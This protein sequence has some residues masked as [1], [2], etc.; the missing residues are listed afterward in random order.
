MVEV[1][2]IAGMQEIWE[3]TQGSAEICV[4]VLDGVVDQSHPCFAGASLTRLSSLVDGVA[5][6]TGMMSGH[7]THVASTI[8]GQQGSPVTGIAPQCRGLIIP[9]F[10]EDRERLLSQ[11]DLSRAINQAVEAGAHIINISGGQLTQSG[12]AEDWLRKAVELCKEQNVLIVAAAGNDGCACLHVPAA[13]PVVLAVGAMDDAQQPL[14]FSNWGEAYQTQGILAPGENILGAVP[15]GGTISKS[16]TSFATPIVSGI[17]AL[18]LSLQLQQGETPDPQKVRAA[19]LDSALPCD[20]PTDAEGSR[21]LVGKLNIPGAMKLIAGVKM[22]GD[23]ET[24]QLETIE[25]SGCSCEAQDEETVKE[26]EPAAAIPAATVAA[27]APAVSQSSSANR[28]NNPINSVAA[29]EQTSFGGGLIYALGVLGYDFGTEARRDSFKQL[30]PGVEID[31]TSVPANPYDARQMVDY[32]GENI[33]EAKSLIWTL[34]LELTPIYAI[35]PVGP[36]AREVYEALQEM[37]AGQVEAED[38][39]NYVDRVSI[40]G[41]LTGRTVRLFS[42]QVLPVLESENTRGLYS[43]KVNSLVSAALEAISSERQ[44]SNE[45]VMRKALSSFLNRIYYDWRNLGQTSQERAINFAATNAFQ[46]AS[47]FSEAVAE[48]MELDSVSVEKSPFCRI[49]SD[50]WDVKLKFFDPENDRRAKRVFR[51]TIDVSDIVP[52]SLGE[53]RSWSTPY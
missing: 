5:T 51:Y 37:L 47:T 16:G 44:E 23:S 36:F 43:W 13:L 39:E 53:V 35:E 42:G 11:L 34:N 7:G 20:S 49:D 2:A 48:G 18:L 29:S 40:S 19:L 27:A 22:S 21:C 32:L 45:Q 31:G 26:S 38:S 15:G 12:E 24:V 9:V 28:L 46:A 14:D 6:P 4:A 52:V 3:Q 10:A 17:A 33:S 41:R 50:C 30:M 8:F 25:A 1:R